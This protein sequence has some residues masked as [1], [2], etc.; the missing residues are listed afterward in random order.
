MS[1]ST[2]IVLVGVLLSIFAAIYARKKL[3][4]HNQPKTAE[5]FAAV[6]GGA[7]LISSATFGTMVYIADGSWWVGF[8]V[9][10]LLY[11]FAMAVKRKSDQLD[12]EYLK[13]Q[14]PVRTTNNPVKKEIE[15]LHRMALRE[16][17]DQIQRLKFENEIL[18][19]QL[20][21]KRKPA[22]HKPKA[23]PKITG[24]FGTFEFDYIDAEGNFSHRIVD[25][26]AVEEERF[27]GYCH[28]ARAIRTF[29]YE[30]VMSDL[31]NVETGEVMDAELWADGV[32]RDR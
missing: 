8:L 15:S 7:L 18:Q 27:S 26:N 32:R 22:R 2:T 3:I 25:A 23:A 13:E 17:D 24:K 11:A 28:E 12:A 21:S 6:S 30:N 9:W 31:V 5:Q 29:R 20:H 19:D 4:E 14:Q 10:A 1:E 16:R